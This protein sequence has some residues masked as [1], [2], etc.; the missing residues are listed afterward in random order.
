ME[1]IKMNLV[2]ILMKRDNLTKNEAK[3]LIKECQ[4][5]LYNGDHEAIQTYLGLEDD[6]IDDVVFFKD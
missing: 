5:A 1:V 2:E 4:E 6:Y 3:Q